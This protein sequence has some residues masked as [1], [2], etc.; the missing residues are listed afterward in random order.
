MLHFNNKFNLI[1]LKVKFLQ[2]VRH[3]QAC[4][5]GSR[6]SFVSPSFLFY[7]EIH[8]FP[9][10]FSFLISLCIL[11]FAFFVFPFLFVSFFLLLSS[12]LS[13]LSPSFFFALP[14]FL[15]SFSLSSLFHFSL[16]FSLSISPY[17]SLSL[18]YFLYISISF[19]LYSSFLS[20]RFFGC[21]HPVL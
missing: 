4:G 7:L 18:A 15:L 14:S 10:S 9:V 21:E 6:S 3:I 1:R 13:F 5:L 19:V 12:F 11:S 8:L 17:L 2:P 16:V 20:F